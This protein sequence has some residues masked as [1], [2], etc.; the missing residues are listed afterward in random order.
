MKRYLFAILIALTFVVPS[1]ATAESF[2][3]DEGGTKPWMSIDA[4]GKYEDPGMTVTPENSNL[5]VRSN[6]DGKIGAAY[7]SQWAF[8]MANDFSFSVDYSFNHTST[9]PAEMGGL[10][11][12]VGPSDSTDRDKGISMIAGNATAAD[13][14]AWKW[15]GLPPVDGQAGDG[16]EF[17]DR[18]SDSGTFTVS[19]D[20]TAR[21]ATF[22]SGIVSKTFNMSFVTDDNFVGIALGGGS[23]NM[24]F[25]NN[26]GAY[27]SNF[28]VTDGTPVKAP[29]A[30][31][32][33]SSALFLL[34]G[35][36]LAARRL[37]KSKKS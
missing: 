10:I 30:P 11:V 9:N 32:P 8:S 18:L 6:G 15:G 24:A 19:Y 16:K 22:A 12:G 35:G 27:F 5:V 7:Y 23:E 17:A 21:T 4:W 13:K 20:A 28:N 33:I 1:V 14:F 3:D 25:G 37:K 26:G 29:V 34:G 36:V 2:F 31:E